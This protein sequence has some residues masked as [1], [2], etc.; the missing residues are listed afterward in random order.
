MVSLVHTSLGSSYL[1]AH[2][3]H[4]PPPP[5][6]QHSFVITKHLQVCQVGLDTLAPKKFFTTFDTRRCSWFRNVRMDTKEDTDVVQQFKNIY[7][8]GDCSDKELW[9]TVSDPF[10]DNVQWACCTQIDTK[11]HLRNLKPAY[12]LQGFIDTYCLFTMPDFFVQK[13]D[14]DHVKKLKTKITAPKVEQIFIDLSAVF[15]DKIWMSLTHTHIGQ[16]LSFCCQ[17]ANSG[18]GPYHHDHDHHAQRTG[19]LIKKR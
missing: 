13:L 10:Q 15:S 2:V 9:K 6:P 3:L 14:A 18:S 16:P 5:T 4:Y 11:S 19:Q 17:C 8:S 1:I 7:L 12:N